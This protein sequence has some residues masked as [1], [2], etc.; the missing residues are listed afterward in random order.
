MSRSVDAKGPNV[1]AS[2]RYTQ[3]ALLR[4][5]CVALGQMEHGA[6]SALHTAAGRV[7]MNPHRER[8]RQKCHLTL[9]T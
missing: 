9:P 6:V 7:W 4:L 8:L 1:P 2:G 3:V 5:P